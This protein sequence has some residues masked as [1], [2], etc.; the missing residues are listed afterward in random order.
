M[1]IQHKLFTNKGFFYYEENGEIKG[2]MTYSAAG[3]TKIII[4]HT[5]IHDD[6][7]GKGVGKALVEAVVAFAR[8]SNIK[9]IPLCPF[10]K[11][12]FE[13]RPELGNVL[14]GIASERNFR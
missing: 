2:E 8:E 7:R 3:T 5:H 6:M 11:S 12:V 9:I 13:K 1:N 14:Y 10:A 4:D